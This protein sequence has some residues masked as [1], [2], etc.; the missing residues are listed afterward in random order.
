MGSRSVQ[1]PGRGCPPVDRP[2]QGEP[3]HPRKE[4]VRGFGYDV[5]TGAL[6]EIDALR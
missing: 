3:V 4:S 5:E 1:R 6:R 2:D